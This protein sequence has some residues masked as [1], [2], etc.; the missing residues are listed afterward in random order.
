[1]STI[2][3]LKKFGVLDRAEFFVHTDEQRTELIRQ[4]NLKRSQIHV[5]HIP[6]SIDALTDVRDYMESMLERDEWYIGMDDNVQYI[7]RARDGMYEKDSGS[8]LRCDYRVPVDGTFFNKIIEEL[9]DRCDLQRTIYGGLGWHENPFF[10]KRKWQPLGY[11][12][13]KTYVKKNGHCRWRW[14]DK[15]KLMNDHAHTFKVIA[16]FGSVAINQFVYV[17]HERWQDGGLGTHEYRLPARMIT[18][19][20]LYEV[21]DGLVSHRGEYDN[22]CVRKHSFNSVNKWRRENGYL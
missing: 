11:C 1:M 21:F 4:T 22:P 10:R 19:E 3:T 2:G 8:G 15:I 16:E 12:K 13:A 17:H 9:I 5:H 7:H 14:N 20:Y 6:V 18:C